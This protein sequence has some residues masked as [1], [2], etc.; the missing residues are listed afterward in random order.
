MSKSSVKS[1][2]QKPFSIALAGSPNCGKSSLY[3]ALTGN[4]QKVANYPGVTVERR[5]GQ[6][7]TKSNQAFDIIDLPG[8]YSFEGRSPDE[9][10]THEILM[11]EREGEDRPDI[12]F[13][14]ADATHLRQHLRLALDLKQTGLPMV[15]VLNMMDIAARDGIEINLKKLSEELGMPVISSVAVRKNGIENLKTF[16]NG[17]LNNIAPVDDTHQD[18]DVKSLQQHAKRIA[19]SVTLAEGI[20][21][22]I[23]RNLDDVF[24]HKFFGPLILFGLLAF[25]FQSVFAWAEAPMEMIDAGVISLQHQAVNGMDNTWYRSLWVDGI[26]AG[27]GSVIIFL[28]QILIL[29]TFILIMEMTGYMARAAFLM[30]RLMAGVGLNGRTFIPLLSSF[31]CAIPGI[32]AART[33]EH[34]KDRLTTILIAPLMTCSARLPVY[35]LLIAAFIP[36]ND[37]GFGMGLQ[38]IVMLILYMVGI[39]SAFLM[40]WVLKKTLT[41]GVPQPLLMELPKYQLPHIKDLAIGLYER[42]RIFLRRAGTIIL[43]AMIL[44]WGLS[45][46][47]NAPE[48][49]DKPDIFYSLAGMLGRGLEVIFAPIGFN[50][51]ISVALIPG[52]AAREVAV[53]ALGTVYSLSGDDDVVASSLVGVLQ[54]NWTLPTALSLL[55]WYVFAPMCLSTLAVAKR[56]TNSTKWAL[57]MAGY[58]FVL[59]YVAAFITYQ[60]A[61]AYM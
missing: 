51:E 49:S 61:L 29:F 60:T 53:A 2:K 18:M 22:K 48:G 36:N 11:G 42:A 20:Q 31:A 34:P 46:F 8:S 45:S 35:T 14:I 28:P 57:F 9:K 40:A 10:V 15:L 32:M 38:G 1:V 59:A 7:I 33:I 24:L 27:V 17:N 52:M 47:P 12:L 54:S 13:C 26:L 5:I 56:E 4:R 43:T 23:T 37:L 50:W 39:I 41:K 58:L 3:N 21:S 16:L 6:F 44:L 30:D 25:M 19:A 55:A